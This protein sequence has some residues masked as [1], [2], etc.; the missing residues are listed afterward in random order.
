[1]RPG[2]G[3]LDDRGVAKLGGRGR[4]RLHA[5]GDALRHERQAVRLEQAPGLAR[6]E[7]AVVGEREGG[8]HDR[9]AGGPVDAVERA[10]RPQRPPQPLGAIRHP[11]ERP[12]RRLRIREGGDVRARPQRLR[13]ALRAHHDREHRLPGGGLARGGGDR[14]GHLGGGRA[15][16]GDEED[17][18]GVDARVGEHGRQRGRVALVRGG[19][20]H[21]DRV[22]EARLRRQ[23]LAQPPHRR[24][25]E[26]GELEADGV[27]RVGGEDAEA[28]RVREHGDPP[29]LQLGLRREERRDVDQLLERGGADHAGLVE[30]RVHA[31]LGAGERRRVRARSALPRRRGAALQRQDRLPPRHAPR[32]P[33]EPARVPERLDVE[34][35][36][37]RRRVV[38]PPLEQVVRRDVGLVPDRDEGGEA[39]APRVRRLEQGQ[40]ERARLRREAE[41]PARRGAGGEGRVQARPRDRDPE[42]VRPDQAGAVRADERDE[43]LLPLGALAPDLGEP[44]GDDDERA[45][46]AAERVL[47]RVEDG[48]ARH[49][50]HGQVDRVGDLGDGPVRAHAG[51]GAPL[52]VDR[53]GGAREVALKHVAEELAADR[54]PARRGADDGDALR[55]EEGAQRGDDGDVVA[56]GHALL[57]ALGLRDR[58]L[59]LDDTAGEVALQLE[60]GAL[61]DAE[62]RPVPGEHLGDEPLDPDRRRALGE[63]LQEARADAAALLVVRDGERRLGERGIAQADVVADRDDPLPLPVRERADERAAVDPVRLEQRLHEQRPHARQAVEAAAQALRRET[64]VELEQRV[65]V[66]AQR[67]PQ[68]QRPTVPEDDV[69]AVRRDRTHRRH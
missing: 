65:A 8:L 14:V 17:E 47:R 50:D 61:E 36:D 31:R 2:R 62:H 1:V 55:L 57:E 34:E 7:P 43:P 16:C 48:G 22:G 42:A 27:E 60:A 11:A 19:A 46:A 59:D 66:P 29:A 45:D 32:D 41:V 38:L 64:L 5:L 23:Q 35:H 51:H 12:R 30:E 40:A 63:L 67:R 3:R 49:G 39:E 54:P 69:D 37:V 18:D 21:V 53:E 9:G 58:E 44:G 10:D 52:G 15:H 56:L 24:L 6:L 4:R 13:H 20:E 28:A 68:A 26:R 33:P 25:R